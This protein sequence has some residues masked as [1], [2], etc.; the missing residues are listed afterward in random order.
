[1]LNSSGK[2]ASPQE[3]AN[4]PVV[5]DQP[6]AKENPA[7]EGTV[8][9]RVSSRHLI[10]ASS[11]FRTMMT[12]GKW[13]EGLR[14]SDGMFHT[15]AEGWDIQAFKIF[16]RVIHLQNWKIPKTVDLELMTKIAVI[17]DFYE[18]EEALG[19]WTDR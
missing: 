9:F 1:M 11:R 10:R 17:V 2:A 8:Q 7:E 19:A 5:G 4:T 16:L 6:V 14:D 13:K 12:G 18:C 3:D 15:R